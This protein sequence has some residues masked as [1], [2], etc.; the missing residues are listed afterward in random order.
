MFVNEPD[1]TNKDDG[2]EEMPA[3]GFPNKNRVETESNHPE[4]SNSFSHVPYFDDL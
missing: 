3:I 1:V 2:T 4:F